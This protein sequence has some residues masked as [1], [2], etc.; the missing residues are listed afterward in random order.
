M[1]DERVR[2]GLGYEIRAAGAVE[3]I[4]GLQIRGFPPQ[5][6]ER[7]QWGRLLWSTNDSSAGPD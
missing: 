3:E 1:R 6:G 4:A 5:L 7:F 2:H